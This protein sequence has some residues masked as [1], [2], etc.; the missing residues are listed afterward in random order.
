MQDERSTRRRVRIA[1]N[2]YERP[3]KKR[4]ENRYEVGYA[5]ANGVW[6]MKTLRA[7]SRTEARAERDAFLAKLRRGEIAPPSNITF[8]EVAA[9]FLTMFETLVAA[10]ERAERTLERYR[11]ALDLHVIP[12]LGERPIQKITADQLAAL[13][14]SRRTA[15]RRRSALAPWTVRGIVTPVRRVFALAV[16]RGYI[17][18][19]PVLRLH[20]DELPRGGAQSEP[21][22][23]S[24]EEVRQLLAC[25]P[26]RYRPLL[27]VAVYTGM[28][29]QEILGVV[30]GDID[31]RE[32]VV[33][34]RAQLSR[35]TK[36]NP[37]RRIDLKTKAGRRDIALARQLEPYLRQ[38]LHATELATG[39]PRLDAYVFT[40]STG[41]P[42]NRNNVAKRRLDKAA[43]AAGLND[44]GVPKLGFH[45]LRHTFASDL[46]RAGVDPVRASRQLGHARPSI[47]LDIYAHEFDRARG[48]DD[49][50]DSIDAAFGPTRI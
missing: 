36:A 11:S 26:E 23:L 1:D 25:S 40:T 35:G 2:L 45:D 3:G 6:R 32:G 39:L 7:R 30:W 28:R 8:A 5:D 22:A 33:R 16:R 37:P 47:T 29:I 38:H 31:F 15:S 4:G 14:A 43:D 21:R 49:V 10:G 13:I 17:A 18:E 42:L 48:L 24:A 34:V 50:R 46:I 41:R 12:T 20:A 44:D 19:N 27:A 9:E